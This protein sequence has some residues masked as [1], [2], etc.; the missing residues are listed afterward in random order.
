MFM[1]R[2]LKHRQ[3]AL[4][5]G[6]LVARHRR[7]EARWPASGG[8]ARRPGRATSTAVIHDD[9]RRSVPDRDRE[10]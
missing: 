10:S 8:A 2:T 3:M 6:R 7:P 1:W 9:N 5:L 4:A